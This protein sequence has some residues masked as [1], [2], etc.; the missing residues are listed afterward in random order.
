VAGNIFF[1][2]GFFTNSTVSLPYVNG[3]GGVAATGT[4]NALV[5]QAAN[6]NLRI[7]SSRRDLK[8]N[9]KDY[10]NG[11]SIIKD[12]RPRLFNWKPQPDDPEIE[13]T[14]KATLPEHGFIVE[15]VFE[16]YPELVTYLYEKDGSKTPIMW[17]TNDVISI[18]VQSVQELSE[19]I[20]ALE[21][22]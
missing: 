7:S 5:R 2:D 15:E 14:A 9:I 11:L 10:S 16:K 20:E 19:R 21:A 13:L 1:G 22:Q 4:T 3:Y 17:K 8:T 18:L 12:L 6:G